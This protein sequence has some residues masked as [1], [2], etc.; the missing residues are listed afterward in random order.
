[1]PHGKPELDPACAPLAS[2]LRFNL[3]HSGQRALIALARQEVGADIEWLKKRRADDIARRFFAPGEQQR[4]FELPPGER[5]AAFFRLW[6]CK[7]AFLK[8]TGEGLSRS[9]RSYE[10]EIGFD[11]ARILWA[12]GIQDAADRFSV[13]PL[14]PGNGYAAALVAEDR[15]LSL[16][17]FRWP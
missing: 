4:L 7:E 10:I 15:R 14:D 11:G 16:R 1:R 13:F 2:E 6:T 17:R 8:V 3:S 5:E 12:R 9:T